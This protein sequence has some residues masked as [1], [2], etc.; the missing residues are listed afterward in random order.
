MAKILYVGTAGSDDRC[1]CGDLPVPSCG[2]MLLVDRNS[3]G[4]KLRLVPLRRAGSQ[5]TTLVDPGW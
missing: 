4:G 3:G 5:H 1:A 2:S